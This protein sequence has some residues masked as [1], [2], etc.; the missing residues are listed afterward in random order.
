MV[1]LPR[2]TAHDADPPST[3]QPYGCG[4]RNDADEGT[5]PRAT[6]GQVDGEIETLEA[7]EKA[8][9]GLSKA[10][11]IG[12]QERENVETRR[13]RRVVSVMAVANAWTLT[14]IIIRKPTLYLN[15]SAN[16]LII[17]QTGLCVDGGL[18]THA[19]TTKIGPSQCVLN[20]AWYSRNFRNFTYLYLYQAESVSVSGTS[21]TEEVAFFGSRGVS[22]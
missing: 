17:L 12:L 20:P 7:F 8:R 10:T 1:L 21:R 2:R 22:V 18:D 9:K 5:A 15:H 4:V 16:L 14:D 19:H 3:P 13:S 6:A 11:P